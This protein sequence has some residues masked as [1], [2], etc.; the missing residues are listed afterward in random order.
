MNQISVK[1]FFLTM[2]LSVI[3][4]N[5]V[6]LSDWILDGDVLELCESEKTDTEKEEAKNEIFVHEFQHAFSFLL[7]NSLP[8]TNDIDSHSIQCREILTPPPDFS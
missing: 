5:A 3:L 2:L 7:P 4:A 8:D 1:T 6:N